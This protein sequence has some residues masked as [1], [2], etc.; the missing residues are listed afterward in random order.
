MRIALFHNVRSGGAK[1]AVYEWTRRLA[2]NH[3]IDVYTINSADHDFCDLRP[4]VH[5]HKTYAFTSRRQFQSPFG[6]LNQLQRWRDLGTLIRVHKQIADEI[7]AG[8]YQVVF[9][10]T[11]IVTFIPILVQYVR[12]PAIY[13]LHEPIGVSSR[14]QLHRPYFGDNRGRKCVDRYDPLKRLYERRLTSLQQ[15]GI[16]QADRLLA[17]STYTRVCMKT[18]YDIDAPVC[19]LGVDPNEFRPL[20]G[21]SKNSYVLSV[22]ELSPRKGFDFI[23]DSLG[24]IPKD[25]RPALR[26]VSNQIITEE[27]VYIERLAVQ[28]GV[29]LQIASHLHTEAMHIEYNRAALCVYAPVLEPFGL[30]PL[31]A[32]AC[33]T[34][35]VGV[36]EGGVTDSIVHER[37]GLLVE[38]DPAKFAMA[39]Q[40]LLSNPCIRAEYGRNGREHVIQNWTWEQSVSALERHLLAYALP[41]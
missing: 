17:N 10:N 28:M 27:K 19:K 20:K 9:A 22:G 6:R 18:A 13:Y 30:V 3:H 16:H 32:M 2:Q 26:I 15:K 11:C 39:I 40:Y 24:R 38:R 41:S 36:R 31:E 35:V 25:Q 12:I 8:E 34:P 23:L 21:I 1:R 14:R 29:T 4:Y 33:G 7:D 37:T 5:Q